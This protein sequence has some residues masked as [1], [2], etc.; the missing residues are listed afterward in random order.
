MPF[1]PKNVLGLLQDSWTIEVVLEFFKLTSIQPDAVAGWAFFIPDTML[2]NVN[3][4]SH[5]RI[6]TWAVNIFG[7]LIELSASFRV[8]NIQ[9]LRTFN[10]FERLRFKAIKPNSFAVEATVYFNP[11]TDDLL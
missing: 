10:G 2:V 3:H 7:Y 8:A 6:T 4:A 5:F 9:T 1:S 11:G